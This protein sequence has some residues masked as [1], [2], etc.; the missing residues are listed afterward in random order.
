[1]GWVAG[2]KHPRGAN[3]HVP[4]PCTQRRR[5]PPCQ[6]S[7]VYCTRTT[8]LYSIC[9]SAVA[10]RQREP[11]YISRPAGAGR[12]PSLHRPPVQRRLVRSRQYSMVWYNG[13]LNESA[14][15]AGQMRDDRAAHGMRQLRACPTHT[16]RRPST[17][18][19][20]VSVSPKTSA[21]P[22]S[23][24]SVG[25]PW[26]AC[27]FLAHQGLFPRPPPTLRMVPY[28]PV[29]TPADL[30]LVYPSLP[31]PRR[32]LGTGRALY[33]TPDVGSDSE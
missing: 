31:F 22:P 19:S 27:T 16:R 10:T 8:A 14:G 6:P 23:R 3:Q 28:A 21:R 15:D 24:Q 33:R 9:A 32:R 29:G 7:H 20:A 11:L 30:T 2:A 25:R 1:M 26:L 5:R 18:R 17:V 13:E 12:R 4:S